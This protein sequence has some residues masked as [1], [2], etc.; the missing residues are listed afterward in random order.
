MR[1]E[2]WKRVFKLNKKPDEN[3]IPITKLQKNIINAYR[4][5][6]RI[7]GGAGFRVCSNE[8]NVKETNSKF[9]G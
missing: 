9:G 1:S 7:F 4:E 2:I 3:Y 8:L 5:G 6:R